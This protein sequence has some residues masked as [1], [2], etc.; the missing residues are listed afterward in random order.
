[1]ESND[2]LDGSLPKEEA[3]AKLE[4][5][6]LQSEPGEHPIISGDDVEGAEGSSSF[7]E[8][9]RSKLFKDDDASSARSHRK[10]PDSNVI[11]PNGDALSRPITLPKSVKRGSLIFVAAAVLIGALFLGWYF[12]DMMNEP[13]R[14]QESIAETLSQEV[15]YD[16]PNLYS[17]MPLDNESIN[18]ELTSSGLTIYEVPAIEGRSLYELIKLPDGINI[19]DAGVMY[20][21]GVDKLP[22][23]D[24][25]K[26]LNGSWDMQVD[27]E[28]GVNI[29]VHFADFHSGSVDAAV[30]SALAAEGLQ[31]SNIE[32]SG[33]DSAGNTYT[34]GS[35]T[36]E[37]GTY[38]W[39]VSALPLNKIYSIDGLPENAVYVGIRMTS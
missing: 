39:R 30:Q 32:D 6:E 29:V 28:N 10:S 18:A 9:M 19:V 35:I 4:Q 22:A 14:Q 2:K 24:A 27:R 17:L 13:K 5:G 12:D 26:L 25:A 20:A 15:P 34:M 11:Y 38:S 23:S 16:P 37:L 1:M 8:G 33:Q 7:L 36:G 31:D 3:V 21:S